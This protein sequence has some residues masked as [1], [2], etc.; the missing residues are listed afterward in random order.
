MKVVILGAGITGRLAGKIFEGSPV[1]ESKSKKDFFNA[2]AGV[3]ISIIPIP[4]LNTVQM[5]RIISIDGHT[6]T[7]ELIKKYRTKIQ[8]LEGISYGDMRQFEHSQTVYRPVF[9]IECACPIN[10][11]HVVREINLDRKEIYIDNFDYRIKYDHLI[12]TIPVLNLIK[13]CKIVNLFESEFLNFF[14]H[15]PIYLRSTPCHTFKQDKIEENYITD[16][17]NPIYRENWICN[18]K[19][20]ESLFKIQ[21]AIKIYPGKIYSN[22][23]VAHLI[24]DLQSYGI[25]C[26]GRYAEW[27]PTIHFWDSYRKLKELK[28][29]L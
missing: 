1:Y 4:E 10:Y 27:N 20:E 12:S 15:R 9:D 14:M 3:Q 19:N 26:I 5:T 21:D 6:P 16:E 2:Y 11:G 18:T 28:K 29:S 17:S 23:S 13:I 24:Q 7:M 8:R 22:P 25:H